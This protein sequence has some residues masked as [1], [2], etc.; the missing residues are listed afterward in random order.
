[1][2]GIEPPGLEEIGPR[3]QPQQADLVLTRVIFQAVKEPRAQP[4]PA[5]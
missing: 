3:V 4:A 2:A 5:S 1:M